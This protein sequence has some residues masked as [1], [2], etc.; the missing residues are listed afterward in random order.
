MSVRIWNWANK[1]ID[2]PFGLKTNHTSTFQAD[3]R[4]QLLHHADHELQPSLCSRFPQARG[5]KN[6]KGCIL[7]NYVFGGWLPD[8]SDAAMLRN[9]SAPGLLSCPRAWPDNTQ[10]CSS[11]AK[12]PKA[13][14]EPWCTLLATT[15]HTFISLP[16]EGITT[17]TKPKYN[18]SSHQAVAI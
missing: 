5:N 14:H 18:A 17:R 3:V 2:L 10:G 9:L 16:Y 8:V 15:I 6:L 12:I 1:S 13:S 7:E 11:E 4:P